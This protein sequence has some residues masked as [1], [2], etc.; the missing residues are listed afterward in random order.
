MTDADE[1]RKTPLDAQGGLLS[2]IS[3]VSFLSLAL[4]KTDALGDLS[5]LF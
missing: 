1:G 3:P 4:V 5:T 2:V